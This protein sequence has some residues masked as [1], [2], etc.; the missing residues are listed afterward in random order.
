[1]NIRNVA[2]LTAIAAAAASAGVS[3]ATDTASMSVGAT[4][5]ASCNV[6]A[7]SLNFASADVVNASGLET[8]GDI[9]VQC[10]DTT[11]YAIGLGAGNNGTDTAGVVSGRQM[12]HTDTTSLLAY[13]LK[14]VS[15]SGTNWDN[16]G[17]NDVEDVGTGVVQNHTVYASIDSGQSTAK[18]GVYSDS[19]TVTVT[20]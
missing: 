12:T 20:F 15:Q 3:A 1:M 9:T 5:V 2:L 17:A 6:T 16:A 10:T 7:P 8:S 4:V 14:S 11:P 13:T 18:L 19:V